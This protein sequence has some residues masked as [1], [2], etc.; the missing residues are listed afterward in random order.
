MR[1]I[2]TTSKSRATR[3]FFLLGAC[4]LL[5]IT[6]I[7]V[8]R[9]A[10]L[11]GQMASQQEQTAQMLADLAEA[12]QTQELAKQLVQVQNE[13]QAIEATMVGVE[14]M[15]TIQSDL[16]EL[17]RDAGCQLRKAAVQPGSSLTWELEN[18]G[19]ADEDLEPPLPGQLPAASNMPEMKPESP[20]R[21]TT[22]QISLTLTG[23][24]TQTLDF[25]DRVHQQP[26]LMR[27]AQIHLSRDG[28]NNGQL[29]VEAN[30]AFHKLVRQAKFET[31]SMSS[32]EVTRQ[33][34][35]Q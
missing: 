17:A 6:V 20:Y 8:P 10:D 26:W 24:L 1:S 22:E 34:K 30:L 12:E 27:V 21:L 3:R 18:E 15:P 19:G 35:I 16:M 11:W 2:V 33:G 7:Q 25:L 5:A 31:G 23:S 32:R 29:V 14:Q 28:E 13:L 9:L 4:G